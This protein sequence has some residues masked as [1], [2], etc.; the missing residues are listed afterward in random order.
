MCDAAARRR[1]VPAVIARVGAV[2]EGIRADDELVAAAG[3][4]DD[5]SFDL[6]VGPHID[7][8]YRLAITMLRDRAEAEDAVQE[9]ALKA[10]RAIGRLRPDSNVRAWFLTIVAN[11]CRSQLRSRWWSVIRLSDTERQSAGGADDLAIG[12]SELARALGHLSPADRVAVYLRYYEDMSI[13]E[14]AAVTRTSVPAARSRVSRAI[15]RLRLQM[16]DPE[17]ER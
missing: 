8:A 15:G 16:S 12:R 14:V 4:G 13:E 10:W 9:A 3:R 7:T 2:P 6:L 5:K 11:H 1:V 17:V